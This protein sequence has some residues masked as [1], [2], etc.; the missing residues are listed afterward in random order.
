MKSCHYKRSV[1]KPQQSGGVMER[2]RRN[3]LIKAPALLNA[4]SPT[5][6]SYLRMT[7][8]FHFRRTI[9]PASTNQQPIELISA[10]FHM[11]YAVATFEIPFGRHS[12]ENARSGVEPN[13]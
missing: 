5:D 12:S 9:Y 3:H 11:L 4:L 10:E 7:G 1:M 2:S 6:S 8:L 13:V